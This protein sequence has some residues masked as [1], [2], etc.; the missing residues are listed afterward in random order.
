MFYGRGLYSGHHLNIYRAGQTG[1][2]DRIWGYDHPR[3]R[4]NRKVKETMTLQTSR[5]IRADRSRRRATGRAKR[6]IAA[7]FTLHIFT[8]LILFGCLTAVFLFH[9]R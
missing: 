8:P 2:Q 5:T 6:A 7:A 3:T 1:V 9:V 4:S